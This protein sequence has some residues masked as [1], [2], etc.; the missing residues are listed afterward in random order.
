MSQIIPLNYLIKFIR[1]HFQT[2]FTMKSALF[3]SA[4][5]PSALGATIYLAGDSTMATGGT[6]SGTAGMSSSWWHPWI[7][8]F[9]Y[10][11]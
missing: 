10:T 4:I 5:I 9:R 7:F 3:L 6:G 2:S 11:C 8:H 1:L